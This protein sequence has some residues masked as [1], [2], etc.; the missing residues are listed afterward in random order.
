[1]WEKEN[2]KATSEQRLL[3]EP[4]TLAYRGN[5]LLTE[6]PGKGE[7]V[8]LV[9]LF[10][11][12]C[13]IFHKNRCKPTFVPLCVHVCLYYIC[14]FVYICIHI[15]FFFFRSMFEQASTMEENPYVIM[16]TLKEYLVPI[17]GKEVYGLISS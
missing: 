8:I 11:N 1:M 17:L 10:T 12:Y 2:W 5:T 6:L 7:T 14:M 13:N 15:L 3:K 9:L 16:W 4:I